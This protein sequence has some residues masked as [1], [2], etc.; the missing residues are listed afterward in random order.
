[1]FE[2]PASYAPFPWKVEADDQKYRRS[3]YVFRR[4]STPFPFLGTFDV[5]NGETACVKRVKSNTPL[6]ALMTLNETLSMEAAEHLALRMIQEASGDDAKAIT[7]G[8]T[9]CTGRTPSEKESQL[10]LDLLKR[11]RETAAAEDAKPM[12]VVARVLLNLD[13][14]ITKE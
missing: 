2:K 9:L 5:P 12:V 4:R 7:R 6:Q 10:L 8:F 1:L 14:T 11:Q 13:E 3:V